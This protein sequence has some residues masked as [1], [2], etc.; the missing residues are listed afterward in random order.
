L[1]SSE[2]KEEEEEMSDFVNKLSEI[3]AEQKEIRERA[4]NIEKVVNSLEGVQVVEK[5]KLFF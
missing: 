4:V 3:E 1:L 2:K 5:K